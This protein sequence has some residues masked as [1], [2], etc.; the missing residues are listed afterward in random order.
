MSKGSSREAVLERVKKRTR[1]DIFFFSSASRMP[2]KQMHMYGE[3]YL[4]YDFKEA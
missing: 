2:I 3:C 4:P 1:I